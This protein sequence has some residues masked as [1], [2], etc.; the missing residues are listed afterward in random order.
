MKESQGASA[1]IPMGIANTVAQR[2]L[3]NG[4][5]V[6]V[7]SVPNS[8]AV[9]IVGKLHAGDALAGGYSLVPTL[10]AHQLKMGSRKY[11]K[12]EIA[13]MLQGM[14]RL[15]FGTDTFSFGLSAFVTASSFADAMQLMSELLRNPRFDGGELALAKKQ[16][17][18][19]LTRRI[20]EPAEMA[21]NVL[22]GK[23]YESGPYAERSFAEAQAELND[24]DC[25]ML[26]R[27][28]DAHVAP[29]GGVI[30][31]VGDV[32]SEVAFALIDRYLGDWR[33][34]TARPIAVVAA[35]LPQ[36]SR[37]DVPVGD[38]ANLDVVI[39]RSSSVKWS[40]PDFCAARIGNLILGGDTI[41]SRLGKI[42]RVKHSLTYG[43]NS[44]FQELYVGGA[45]WTISLSTDAQKVESALELVDKV[46]SEFVNE[47]VTELEVSSQASRAVEAFL[48]GLRTDMK[49]ATTIADLEFAGLG[50]EEIDLYPQRLKAV[51]REQVNDAIRVHFGLENAVTVVAGKVN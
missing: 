35:P 1:G 17:A 19:D 43:I 46:T 42:V 21:S 41:G 9:S 3:H 15:G 32:D 33:G 34:P 26:R 11:S 28:Y 45:P 36:K 22:A 6:L 18:S 49:V 31:I 37:F 2:L 29:H 50:V 39:G 24:I 38:E 23:L 30:S 20:N 5:K 40:N 14:G 16:W 7:K 48:L 27:F 47:G 10:V 4:L 25:S 8:G 12:R 13:R 51:T 44:G